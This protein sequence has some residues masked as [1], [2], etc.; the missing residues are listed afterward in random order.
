MVVDL[1]LAAVPEEGFVSASMRD[2]ISSW[3]CLRKDWVLGV[4]KSGGLKPMGGE[5][6]GWI[7]VGSGIVSS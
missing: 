3:V 5:V 6:E 7:F 1:L 2:C 4:L